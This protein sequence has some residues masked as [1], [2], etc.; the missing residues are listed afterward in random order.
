M[1]FYTGKTGQ[2]RVL[3][4]FDFGTLDTA[5]YAA[6]DVLTSGAIA[7]D[8]TRFLGFSGVIERVILKETSSGALQK[9][10]IRMW[11]FGSAITP[12]ARNSPQAFNGT[13]FD[14]LVGFFDTGINWVDGAAGVCVLQSSLDIKYVCQPTSKTLY[15]V[16]VLQTSSKTFASGATIKG[17]IV[18]RRD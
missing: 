7:V 9:P 18:L 12:A 8:A 11:I 14:T 13:Q 6:N 5:T 17:Q 15:I 3:R 2:D 1:E 10:N 16:P 4:A